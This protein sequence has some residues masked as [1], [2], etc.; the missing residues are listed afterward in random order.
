MS[1]G[2]LVVGAAMIAPLGSWVSS[3]SVIAERST[4]SRQRPWYREFF[5]QD[6][7]KWI[8]PSNSSSTLGPCPV[9]SRPVV[10]PTS[11]TN[12]AV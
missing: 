12:S 1:S 7:Q 6:R 9:E 3:F 8:V 10:S 2:R 11:R 4:I 5:S